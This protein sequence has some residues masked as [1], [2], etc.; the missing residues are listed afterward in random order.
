MNLKFWSGA[1]LIALAQTLSMD[2]RGEFLNLDFNSPDLSRL[3]PGAPAPWGPTEDLLRGWSV[4]YENVSLPLRT[5]YT[6]CGLYDPLSL[7]NAPSLSG[8]GVDFGPYRI[9]VAAPDDNFIQL[10]QRGLI[11]S[12]AAFLQYYRYTDTPFQVMINGEKVTYSEN[13]STMIGT[14]DVSKYAGTEARLDFVFPRGS[15][16]EFDVVGFLTVPEPSTWALLGIGT[17]GLA[18]QWRACRRRTDQV[19]QPCN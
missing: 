2:V 4:Q 17:A 15:Y 8:T 12:N 18:W 19:C 13:E 3:Q 7:K 6:T 11:P 16:N 14:L 5:R 1:V 10:S 9:F